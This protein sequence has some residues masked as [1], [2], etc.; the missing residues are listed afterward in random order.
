MRG[1]VSTD[2]VGEGGK[3]QQYLNIGELADLVH[4]SKSQLYMMTSKRLIPHL[5]LGRVVRFDP[6]QIEQWLAA[7]TVK[8]V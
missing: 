6:K 1:I 7:K 2:I 3:M 4:L 5:K 8:G